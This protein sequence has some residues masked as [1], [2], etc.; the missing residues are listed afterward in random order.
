[1]T[2]RIVRLVWHRRGDLRLRDNALYHLDDDDHDDHD[3][4]TDEHGRPIV[5][6]VAVISLFVLDL[7]HFE[8]QPSLSTIITPHYPQWDTVHTGPHQARLLL[9]ALRSLR[10]SLRAKGSGGG[11]GGSGELFVRRGRP[12]EVIPEFITQLQQQF[13]QQQNTLTTCTC[14]EN[15]NE[16]AFTCTC[17][18]TETSVHIQV[19]WNAVPGTE[20]QQESGDV[21]EALRKQ[22]QTQQQQQHPVHPNN[23]VKRSANISISTGV[24]CSCTLYHPNDLPQDKSTWVAYAHPH[25]KQVCGSGKN[26]KKK[27]KQQQQ[28]QC[29]HDHARQHQQHQ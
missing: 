3:T 24:S 10:Q 2:R 19:R 8:P 5:T 4:D 23:N 29:V 18:T 7:S 22:Q 28:Q 13:Q 14:N 26:K 1:M 11:G 15:E 17:C 25:Q 6:S 12:S 20:E 9:E 16:T 27:K 21:Q